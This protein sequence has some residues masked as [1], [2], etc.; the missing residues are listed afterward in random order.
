MP[1]APYDPLKEVGLAERIKPGDSVT[2]TLGR[3][4]VV[5]A[6]HADKDG[7]WIE[8][9]GADDFTWWFPVQ[10]VVKINGEDVSGT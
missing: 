1:K 4:V 3:T 8:P 6:V 2:T 9:T 5:G 7:F 10:N